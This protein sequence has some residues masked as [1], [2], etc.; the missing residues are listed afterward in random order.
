[1]RKFTLFVLV[2]LFVAGCAGMQSEPV[3]P[4][5][6]YL[7][8]ITQ[9]SN[10]QDLYLRNVDRIED[11]E[12]KET[13]KKAFA[14]SYAALEIWHTALQSGGPTVEGEIAYDRAMDILINT[15]PLVIEV[16]E[17]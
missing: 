7:V 14:A 3:S 1:M 2:A 4:K 9:Y 16:M 11:L 15:L 6:A 10:L 13:I 17:E 8:A 5:E 12:T